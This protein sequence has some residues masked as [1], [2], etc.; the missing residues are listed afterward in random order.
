M[1]IR[2]CINPECHRPIA[3]CNGFVAARDILEHHEGKREARH[4]R[5]FCG[6]CGVLIYFLEHPFAWIETILQNNPLPW[7]PSI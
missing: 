5:E 7:S 1:N 3:S 2:Y 6:R 4:I